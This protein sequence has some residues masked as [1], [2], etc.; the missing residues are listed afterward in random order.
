MDPHTPAAEEATLAPSKQHKKPL[1]IV[2]IGASAGGLNALEELFDN[3]PADSG[4]AFVVV[5]HLSPDFKSRMDELLLQHTAMPIQVIADATKMAP[6]TV[7]LLPAMTQLAVKGGNLH[8]T[9][10]A[11]GQHVDLPIDVFFESLA[12]DAGSKAVG[13]ILSGTGKDGSQGIQAIH[14]KGGLVI[15]QSPESAQYDAMPQSAI[16][17]GAVDYILPPDEIPD[18]LID[19]ITNPTKAHGKSQ[20]IPGLTDNGEFAGIFRLLQNSFHLNFAIYKLGTVERRIRR[21]MG[22][23]QIAGVLDYAA[24]LASDQDELDDLYHDLLI[25]VTEFFRDEEAFRYLETTIIPELFAGRAPDQELRV[26]SAGCATGEEA[27]SLAILLTE[28]AREQNFT[29]KITVFATD[30]HRRSLETAA[31]GIY[32]RERL[33]KVDPERLERN[34][35]EVEKDHFK[36]NA[37][38]RKM[39]VFARHD[40]TRDIPFSRIDLVLCR[41]LLI[42]LKSEAQKRVI[43]QLHFALNRNGILF[44]G[45]SEGVGTFTAEFEILSAQ[46]NLFRR[47]GQRRLMVEPEHVLTGITPILPPPLSPPA[48]KRLASLDKQVLHDYDKLLDK[49][50]PPG[51]LIDGKRQIIHYFGNVAEYLKAPRGRV[52]NDILA[53]ADDNLHIALSN[54][55]QKVNKSGE[56]IVTRNIR[57][58]PGA[59]EYLVDL[60]VDP[61][62][63]EKT[64]QP[65]YHVYFERVRPVEPVPLPELRETA[66]V[67]LFEFTTSYRQ[68]VSD[69]EAELQA[70]RADF[71]TTQENLQATIEELNATNEELQAANEELQ[72]TNEELNSANEELQSANEELFSVSSEL[73]RS[74]SELKQ[75]NIEHVNL[76]DSIESGIICLDRQMAIRNYNHAI[77]TIFKLMPQ[78]IGRP[79]D[80]IAYHLPDQ[81]MMLNDVRRVLKDCSPIEKEVATRE[82]KWLLKR[83]VPLKSGTGL[84][85][86]AILM[87]TDI[88]K[89]KE[90]ETVIRLNEELQQ[91]NAN[92]GESRAELESQNKKLHESYNKLKAEVAERVRMV[93]EL[94]EKEQMLIQQNR[95]AAM[96]EMLNNIAHQW[97]Q[98]LNAVGALVQE[99]GL[100]HSFGEF[101]QELLDANIAKAMEIVEHMSHTIDDFRRFFLPDKEKRLFKVDKTVRKAISLIGDDFRNQGITIEINATGEPEAYGFPNEYSQVLLNIMMN[102]RDALLEQ[103]ISDARVTVCIER[104]GDRAVVTITDNAG[105][106]N[107]EIMDRVFDAYFTTKE[108]GKGTGIG[109]FMSKTIIEKNMGG[110]LTVRNVGDGAEFRIE[111]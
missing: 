73:E 53:M 54:A 1:S 99:I 14:R 39:L 107:E 67:N 26:W 34:F 110:R 32:S 75:L 103:N 82:G 56:S 45:K 57:I 44:C 84:C 42:Y 18:I 70:T 30:V 49:H 23:R 72:S 40:L 24:I 17:T 74:N 108:L 111:V 43:A 94:R 90:A 21:R 79:L 95:M 60:T 35:T 27:Y 77:S 50:I 16:G 58:S 91:A 65:H 68:H 96:G 28:K 98:P 78:D 83:I 33:A 80:H 106:I 19:Q 63:Y 12:E 5:Q 8:L 69:L 87:F 7:Y 13:V 55:L 97:R 71:L 104:E 38:L 47:I 61:I 100:S 59:G 31:Q 29:G 10:I 22:F 66:D 46:H 37:D 102:A 2:G 11:K 76:L 48:Q 105:G 93:E 101:S 20:D 15:V 25:G 52:E 41:N 6:N 51:V 62:P 9:G 89:I 88:S 64:G 92:L 85:E 4:M 109:L 86:G 36:V 3:M 81:E